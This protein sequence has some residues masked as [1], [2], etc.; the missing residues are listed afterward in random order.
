MIQDSSV[1]KLLGTLYAAPTQPE[2]WDI[3]M[4]RLC[5]ATGITKSALISYDF[6]E[7]GLNMFSAMRGIDPESLPLYQSHFYKFDEWTNRLRRRKLAGRV[8]R[9]EEVWQEEA[10]LKSAFYNDF[11]RKFNMHQVAGAVASLHPTLVEVF[12]IYRGPKEEEFSSEHLALLEFLTPHLQI[13]LY[14]RRKLL[15]LESRIIDIEIALDQIASALILIDGIGKTV[16]V[17]KNARTILDQRDGLSLHRGRLAAQSIPENSRLHEILAKAILASTGKANANPGAMRVSRA[18]K[19][20]IQLVAAPLR[21]ETFLIPG[22]AVAI[23]FLTDPD[24]KPAPPAEVLRI[25][26]GLTQAETTL[27]LSLLDGNSL[28]EAANLSSVGRET[29]R[30]QVKSIFQKTGTKRQSELTRVLASL[31]TH[32]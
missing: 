2:H 9:G 25:L 12:C 23:V 16:F 27:A 13:A 11:L 29:V 1:N 17:N 5:L 10:L 18:N 20:P 14:T 7:H 15:A 26:F 24:Q 4:E 8:L 21:S 6:A 31:N 19:R 28:S 3:F 22:K 30:S 32:R